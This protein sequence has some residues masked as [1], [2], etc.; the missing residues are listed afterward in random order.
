MN[1]KQIKKII[2]FGESE[3]VEFKKSTGVLHAAFETVCAFLNGKGGAV[4]VGV[5][6]EGRIVG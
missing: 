1:L 2:Q 6:N 4:L 3:R 5:T